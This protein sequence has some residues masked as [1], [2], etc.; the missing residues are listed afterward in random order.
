VLTHPAYRHGIRNALVL[1][2]WLVGFSLVS[3]GSLARDVGHPALAAIL[4][5]VLVWAG[6]GQILVYGGLAAGAAPLAIAVAVCL[7]SVRFLP[8]TMALLPYLRRPG[9]STAHQLWAAHLVSMTSWLE[10]MHRLPQLP[11]E[12][13]APYFFGFSTTCMVV[14]A[15][16]TGIGYVLVGAVPPALAAGLLSL[17]PIFFTISLCGGARRAADWLAVG[18]GFTLQPLSALMV[19]RDFDLLATGLLGG[20]AA[21]AASRAMRRRSA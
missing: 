13:R 17:T 21:Y 19:G 15:A 8:M 3:V 7:S 11:A 9:Q 12:D 10:G 1:P 18:L 20:T 4:S 14:A 16:M 2:A 6:P 5:T